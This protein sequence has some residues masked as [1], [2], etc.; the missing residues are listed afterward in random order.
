V[1]CDPIVGMAQLAQ[2]MTLPAALR[3]RMFAE[4]ASY[5]APRRKAVELSGANGGSIVSECSLDYSALSNSELETLA[6][7]LH[8]PPLEA[9][10]DE[11]S[12]IRSSHRSD[13]AI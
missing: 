8:K 11:G 10:S 3:A 13:K 9:A 4:L 1:D 12:A 7:L 2:D 5:V 6:A